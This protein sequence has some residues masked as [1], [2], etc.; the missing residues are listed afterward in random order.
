MDPQKLQTAE[1]EEYLNKIE[2]RKNTKSGKEKSGAA[3]TTSMNM[4]MHVMNKEPPE[5]PLK[6]DVDQ[7]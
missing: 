1:T 6:L 3:E 2:A 4:R 5:Q 7:Y